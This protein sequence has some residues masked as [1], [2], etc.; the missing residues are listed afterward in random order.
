[1]IQNF[2]L[3]E[4]ARHARRSLARACMVL[5]SLHPNAHVAAWLA[6]SLA[7]V[8]AFALCVKRT[9]DALRAATRRE[10]DRTYATTTARAGRGGAL[11]QRARGAP[12]SAA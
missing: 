7:F 4:R 5:D 3:P 6:G 10:A 1:M 11:H 8:V 2:P 9:E 12:S